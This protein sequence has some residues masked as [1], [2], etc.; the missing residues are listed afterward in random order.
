MEN[1]KRRNTDLKFLPVKARDILII[2]FISLFLITT[3][4]TQETDLKP[5]DK[6]LLKAKLEKIQNSPRKVDILNELAYRESRTWYD[7]AFKYANEALSLAKKLKYSKGIVDSYCSLGLIYFYRSEYEK[8]KENYDL[9]LEMV[10]DIKYQIG[11]AKAYN[12]IARYHQV[13]GEYARALQFFI[14][15]KDICEDIGEKRE[16]AGAYYGFGALYYYDKKKYKEALPY[17]ENTLEL[18][19][20]IGDN[21]IIT[22][23]H[24]AIGEMYQSME[25]YAKARENFKDCLEISQ[26]NEI[27]YNEANAYEG[28]G[29]I[30]LKKG[31]DE[32]ISGNNEKAVD[33]YKKALK[34]YNESKKIFLKVKDGLQIAEIEKRIGKLYH[35]W[36]DIENK[37]ENYKKALDNLK[38]ALEIATETN[39]NIPK[40]IEGVAEELFQIYKKKNE[41]ENALR[42]HE[43]FHEKSRL[44]GK[45]EMLRLKVRY[46]FEKRAERERSKKIFLI[47][48]FAVSMIV[49]IVVL[50][51]SMK[52]ARQKQ[53]LEKSYKD[54]ERMSEIG[55]VI[56]SSL[57]PEK[58][59]HTVYEHIR[60]L[61]DADLFCIYWYDEELN[62]LIVVGGKEQGVEDISHSIELT[63]KNRPAVKCFLEKKILLFSDFQKEY[64]QV[65]GEPRPLPMI[66]RWF[67]SHI[68]L[69]LVIKGS[70][71]KKNGVITVQSSKKGAYTG[72]HVNILKSIAGYAAIALDNANAYKMIGEQKATIEKQKI[73]VEE[74]LEKEKEVSDHKD[75]LMNTLSHQ[76]KTPLSIIKSSAQILRDY[77]SNLSKEEIQDQLNKIFSN[78]DR[79]LKL[80][81]A[82]LLYS[83][84]FNPDFY[85]LLDTC[86]TFVAEIKNNEGKNH[87]IVFNAAEECG[88]V[89]M[90]EDLMKIILHNLIVNAI[91]YSS[92]GSKIIIDL[93]CETDHA[94]IRIQDNGIG[95]PDD[96]FKMIYE[97][98]HRGSNVGHVPGTGLGL[99]IAKRYVDLHEGKIKIESRL[100]IGTTVTVTIPRG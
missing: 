42:Y 47:L 14:K 51:I 24:Y 35:Q 25:K 32:K 53:K 76:Y 75:S 19:K 96:Y 80:I 94:V 77:W 29:D 37:E 57:S 92:K 20:K 73:K 22:S 84:R 44:L 63:E 38:K 67:N 55:Q 71:D 70:E 62:R 54:I 40:T 100:N 81:N 98:F 23:A 52:L 17:F 30:Y 69:P 50:L 45:N 48:G 21:I 93:K 9:V 49:L 64:S 79:M 34:E 68:F 43:M 59:Y 66:G 7:I 87:D 18:G 13:R 10:K 97:R 58:I 41:N 91:N 27:Q 31:N 39:K 83:K 74:A 72:Y 15:S 46:D 12:G 61:M 99:S 85:D 1:K 2:I 36:G 56:T 3:A 4:C 60:E 86:K 26:E 89:K 6:K 28:Y 65:F 11:E 78:I 5:M 8:S 16:L 82:L 95:I 90:D 33:F 88:K